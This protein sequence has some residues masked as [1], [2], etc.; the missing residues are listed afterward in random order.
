MYP[1]LISRNSQE[2][3]LFEKITKIKDSNDEK[4]K[5]KIEKE[6]QTENTYF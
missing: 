4:T 1:P 6:I 5:V 3:R 2:S